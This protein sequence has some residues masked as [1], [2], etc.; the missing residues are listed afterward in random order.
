MQTSDWIVA[1]VSTAGLILAA[2]VAGP[3]GAVGL[4][5]AIPVLDSWFQQIVA[6]WM[7]A[8]TAETLAAV[9]DAAALGARAQ[10]DT[11]RYAAAA[12]WREALSRSRQLP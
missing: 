4:I 9:A 10:T 5:K 1:G 8:Q 3:A 7:T 6:L 11:D 2:I 12:K